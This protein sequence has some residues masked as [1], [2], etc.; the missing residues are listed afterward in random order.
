[1]RHYTKILIWE[2]KRR[3]KKLREFR[4]LMIRYFNNSQV[5]LG[6]GRVEED[7]A[8]EAKSKINLLIAEVHSIILNSGVN[9][10]LSWT[11]PAG[12]GDH[13]VEVDL[14]EN[15]FDLDLFDIG[16][17]NLLAV[18]D[19]V[20]EKYD[21]NRKAVF[22]RTC[23]PFLYLG[24]MLDIISDL[25]FIVMGIFGFNQQKIK[26]STIGRLIKGALYLITVI[27]F[28]AILHLLGF[29]EPVTQHIRKLLGLIGE[30]TLVFDPDS[31]IS[32]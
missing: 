19:E 24:W 15:I 23:N 3:I 10:V 7:A 9:P 11:P 2:N 16:P 5:G 30:I 6:G 27:A 17:S 4:N 1:M 26:M 29:L 21:S 28:L 14:I 8:Q 22:V 31:V 20:I 18:I 25:P 32:Q 12:L 13:A